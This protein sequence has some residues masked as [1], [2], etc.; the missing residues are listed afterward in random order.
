VARLLI[1]FLA[2]MLA[3]CTGFATIIV[4]VGT[5]DGLLVCEDRR[6]TTKSSAG[7]VSFADGNKAQQLGKFGFFAVAGDLSG[8]LTNSFGQSITTF[9]V[10]S[11]I[12]S[13]FKTHDI[14]QFNEQTALEFEAHLR[15]QLNKKPASPA[16]GSQ[17]T[18]AQTE[19]LLDWMDQAG[20][21]H[22][23]VVD[24]ATALD[25][26]GT[27]TAA[28]SPPRMVGR[29]ISLA[30]FSTSK[31]RVIG[32]GLLGYNAI[33]SGTDP[34]LDDLRQDDELKPFLSNFVDATAVDSIAAVRALKKLIRGISEKQ[35]SVS[36][37]GLD[38]GPVSDCFLGT[39][40]GIKNINQ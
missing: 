34:T 21:A 31:P 27:V 2:L 6:V 10:L 24:M 25:S 35:N 14:Q 19:V 20:Q 36:A 1:L 38:V 3:A 37:E 8:R 9:D 13:F 5:K 29:F 17:G 7:Q 26:N 33:V 22:L 16:Q 11:E 12:P 30:A 28:S 40:D 15:D 39:M 18:R 4:A 23:Y 32:R